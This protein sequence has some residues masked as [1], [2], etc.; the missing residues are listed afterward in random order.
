MVTLIPLGIFLLFS[1]LALLI[2]E[3]PGL[4]FN[5]A[6][7]LRMLFSIKYGEIFNI[8]PWQSLALI[9]GAALIVYGLA[10]VKIL[11]QILFGIVVTILA[12]TTAISFWVMAQPCEGLGCLGIAIAFMVFSVAWILGVGLLTALLFSLIDPADPHRLR[13][14]ALGGGIFLVVLIL[15]LVMFFVKI[16]AIAK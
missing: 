1:G 16:M 7:F 6:S 13:K 3:I 2:F 10:K 4:F 9:M 15:L 14:A 5:D 11:R 12:A 8:Q